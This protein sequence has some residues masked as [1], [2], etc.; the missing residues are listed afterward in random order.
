MT[1]LLQASSY[2]KRLRD[3][4]LEDELARKL[5]N[6]PELERAQFLEELA[7]EHEPA[8]LALAFRSLSR[9]GTIQLLCQRLRAGNP[10]SREWLQL[11]KDKIGT[12]RLLALVGGMASGD[13]PTAAFDA[14]YWLPS[15]LRKAADDPALRR[16]RNQV[17]SAASRAGLPYTDDE[18]YE[19][20]SRFQESESPRSPALKAEFAGRFGRTPGAIDFVMRWIE[21]YEFPEKARNRIARQIAQARARYL[22]E[23]SSR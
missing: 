1:E 21:G 23:H 15:I 20:Y 11:G 13:S 18:I 6:L 2:A 12:R 5:R 4:G 7:Q 8:A 22:S 19:I 14:L 9:E 10:S 3:T 16:I 17:D